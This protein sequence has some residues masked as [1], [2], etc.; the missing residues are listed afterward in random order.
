MQYRLE[1]DSVGEKRMQRMLIM[2]FKA[3]EPMKIL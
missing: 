2:V 1:S 3:L